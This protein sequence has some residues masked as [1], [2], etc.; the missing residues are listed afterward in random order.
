V[1]VHRRRGETL[2]K[3]WGNTIRIICTLR[4]E[5]TSLWWPL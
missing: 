4:W 3:L 1:Y 5:V 2:L